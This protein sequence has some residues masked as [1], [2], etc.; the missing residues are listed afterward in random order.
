MGS[1][2][3]SQSG[4]DKHKGTAAGGRPGPAP[5]RGGGVRAS[6]GTNPCTR[7]SF[8][9]KNVFDVLQ[10]LSES[11]GGSPGPQLDAADGQPEPIVHDLHQSL[12]E[13]L[14]RPEILSLHAVRRVGRERQLHLKVRA[15]CGEVEKVFDVLV[16]TGAQVSLVKAGL[17]PPECLTDSRKPVRLKVANGQYMVGGTKE[18]A[19]GLQFVNH[20]ELSRPDLGKEIL[21]HGRFYEAE[22]DWDMIVGYDFMMETDSGVLP[23]QASMTLYQDD[24][25]SWLSSPEHHVE[26]QW[27]HPERNQL[28]VAALDTEPTGPANQEY[29]VRPEVAS[30]V[31]AD[32][33]AS[34]LALD[35]FSSGTSAHLRVC[36][37]Y[38][39]AQ[40]SAWKKHW[41][42]HQGL[43]W[44]HCPRWDI[45]RAIAKIRKDRSK[46]VLVVPMGCT[47]EESTRHWVASLTNMTLNKVVLPAGESVYQDAKGQPMPPQRWPTEFHYVDGG[48][49]QADATDFVCVNRII[50]EPW[51]QCFAVP[52]VDIEESESED[53]LTEEEWDLV[54]GYMDQPFHDWG[55]QREGKGQD[56]AWWEVDSIVSGSYDGNTFVQRVLDHLSSQDEPIGGNPPTYGDLFRGK[57]RDGPL[58][59]LGRPPEPKTSG[60]ATPQVSSVVQVPGKAKAESDDCPKIQALR[61]RL[62]Q[63]YGD[64]FFSGKPVFPPPVRGPYGE[65]KIRLKQDPRVYRHREFA[66][67]GERK[68]A[69][70]KILRDFIQRGWL[71]PCH[72]EWASP[73]FVVPKK[74]AGE[75]RLVVDYRGLNAQTQHDS[76]TLPLIEDMLQKQHRR[77][78]FTVIDLKHGYHQMPLAEES[79]ACTAMSTP[80][81]PLQWKVMPMGVTNGNAAFQRMLENLLEPVRDC[82]DPFVD[83]VI[84]AS[85]DP[86]MSYE[87]LLEA[88]ER[89]VTRVLDLLVRHKLT[90]SSD[91]ATIA[92]SEVV[93]AG[94]VV[95]NGQ[96][97]PIPGKVAAIE[98]WEKPKT[99]SELRAY[100]GFCNYYSGY[101]KMYAEYAAPMTT[102]LKGN[103][104]ETKKGS[105]K[106]LVW[107]AESDRAFE[108]MKQALLSAVGLHLVDPDRGFVLRTDAS[109]YAIGAVLEQVLDD[110]RHVP[111]AFWSRVLAEGQRRTWT[112]REKEAYAIVMALRKWAGYIAL[113]PVTVCTDHQ[114]LQSWH[115]EHVDTPSGPASRRA[116]WHETLAKFDLTVVY[117]PGKDNTVADCLSRWAYPASKGMTDISAHGDEAETAEAKRIIEMERLM[118]EEGAKC[119][120]VMAAD[121]PLA[122]RV[123]RAVS[124]LAPEGAE[125]DKHLFPESCLQDDWTDDYAK[126]EAFAAE[127][128]AVTDP[129]DGQKWP[130][131]LTEEDGKLY[132]NGKLLVPESRVLELCEAWHHHMLHPGV[133]KQALDMQRRFEIDHIVLYTAIKKV[134]KGC[135]VCQACNPD[136]RNVKGEPQWTPVP[137]QPMESVAMDVFSMPEVHIGKETFDCVVLCV[138]RH[139]G[140]VVAVPARKKGLLAKEVAVMMI[141]HWLTVFD[142]PRTICSDRGPQ[143]TGGW[144]KAMCSLMGIRHAKSVAYL[145]R[146]NGRAEVAGRQLFEKLRKIHITNPR[147]NWFEEMWPAL[148]AHHDTPT[149]GGLSPHQILFGRD[150]LGRG[151]PLSGDGMA[152]DAKEFFARQEQTARDIRQ[153]L[154]KEH[155]ERQ[156]S[157]PSSTAQKFRV[158][159]PVWV[160]R[161]R[162]MGT[163]R[164]KTWFTPGEVVRRIGEDTYRIKVGHGQFRERH[165]SQLRVRE[166]DL[167]GQHV[168]LSYAAHEADSDDDYAEQDD[169]TV[170]KI[171]A[172]RPKASAPGGLEFK[173]RW[174]GYGPSHDTWEPVSS[175]V[176]RVNTPFMEYIRK[177]K[178][179]IH[180][181]DLAALTRAI[182]A[183]GA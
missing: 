138:D 140:Y 137:D 7:P 161:P 83:D 61:A 131:G 82:A 123:S 122:S 96:R 92:V 151:L 35:A 8:A 168:S 64:T 129:D 56:K 133:K 115:K 22:M 139:S 32:L 2:E 9:T 124:V 21:L 46:A 160:I 70:E 76:Y 79:R 34:D 164:T 86:S 48:L 101:I 60:V 29:G 117:I 153:Q 152:M 50:A 41:G 81:G 49:D 183:R 141:R 40:D 62:K 105:K 59:H 126:S 18:A 148:K 156:K 52:P 163:H 135:S 5:S 43:M 118:E 89:D 134:R 24:Q 87:E 55:N 108:G 12:V 144:F 4:V 176:P 16:D 119:F 53:P 162:P 77:R 97:K 66:L 158:G 172:Q 54:Q 173:V 120:V 73:C 171:L 182:A 13:L 57:T 180:V 3:P 63:K 71:E 65:A 72:S 15:L 104:E 174:R 112:P 155:A 44:I 68:E 111:V 80:L 169:Y 110:G 157:A 23:A 95:G 69:M 31:V 177:H 107:T 181:S 125:S 142:I 17:L 47:E 93:F 78:I 114:S 28:E 130:K 154:E 175:F 98:H 33:G 94:H 37:K 99:V 14:E 91:K 11:I 74:V 58:G 100:L 132:R 67:R 84:I 159:D 109:D 179:K 39:S 20:R 25:L 103:R 136:N 147:R 51:R 170:E 127:Y 75:W 121:A 36:E 178:T 45:P 10:D 143:F 19:I 146:S 27:I 128:R 38:W 116:R 30:R 6:E 88:H 102:M 42:P 165:E 90:G 145:S 106:A 85:G 167:R 113:H 1:A 26:C 149:P 150:P 166:P